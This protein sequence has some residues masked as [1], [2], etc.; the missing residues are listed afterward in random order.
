MREVVQMCGF[1]HHEGP[2]L[3][4]G[5]ILFSRLGTVQDESGTVSLW[6]TEM[7]EF[8]CHLL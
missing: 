4:R 1:E 7:M 3:S 6:V 5:P 2:S 8:L